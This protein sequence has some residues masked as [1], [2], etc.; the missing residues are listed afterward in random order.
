MDE[1]IRMANEYSDRLGKP[2]SNMAAR[3]II[4]NSA[5]SVLLQGG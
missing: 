2:G 1:N 5:I 3:R 4:R